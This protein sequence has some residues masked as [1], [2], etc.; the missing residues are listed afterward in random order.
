MLMHAG[1]VLQIFQKASVLD[2]IT[3]RVTAVYEKFLVGD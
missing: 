3:P 1:P 2:V